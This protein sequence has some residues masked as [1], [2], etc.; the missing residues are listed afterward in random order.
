MHNSDA[1]A[2]NLV[3]EASEWVRPKSGSGLRVGQASEWV[4][5]QLSASDI[6]V[7]A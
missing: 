1:L 5:P 3:G 6:N 2:G 4:R 7:F